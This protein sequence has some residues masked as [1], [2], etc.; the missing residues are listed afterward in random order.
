MYIIESF[1][2]SIRRACSLIGIWRTSFAY[3]PK[4]KDLDEA[5]IRVRLKEH[6]QKRRRFG[7]PRLHVLLRRDG[8]IINHKRTE[9][10]YKEEGLSL[11][12]KRRKK[13]AS[14]LR[15]EVPRPTHPNH[16]WSMDFMKDALSDGRKL[17]VLP[18]VDEYT[19]KSFRIEVDTSITGARVVRILNEIAP[20]EGLP[21]IIIIDNGPEF[22]G[23]A[24]DEWAYRRGVKLFFIT[25]GKP[26]EN[27]YMESFN[28]RLRDE[29]LNLHYFTSLEYARQIIEEWR[30]DYNTER[31]HS[32]LDNLTPEE[33]IQKLKEKKP[34][35][36]TVGSISI[37]AGYST[38]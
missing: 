37:N 10:I 30:V 5:E 18:V 26:V 25:P 35:A 21:E 13:M 36:I 32:S 20:A 1:G 11:R 31:P 22:I 9:R 38:S 19:K 28:G 33:F 15:V 23:R 6:A 2:L 14:T 4:E 27:M 17:K 8:F 7:C 3:K 29:C 24:L 16:I 12:I 34:I